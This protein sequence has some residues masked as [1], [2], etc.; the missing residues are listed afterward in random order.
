MPHP[1]MYRGDRRRKEDQRKAKQEAKKVRRAE[2][3]ETGTSGPEIADQAEAGAV[4]IVE[5]VWFSPSKGADPDDA[6]Q[7]GADGGRDRRLDAAERAAG[8]ELGAGRLGRAGV[9]A[10]WRV[11][12]E[13]GAPEERGPEVFGGDGPRMAIHEAVRAET[14]AGPDDEAVE[15][16]EAARGELA[17]E[18]D[19]EWQVQQHAED[20]S[21][22]PFDAGEPRDHREEHEQ[23]IGV[24]HEDDPLYLAGE[25]VAE[26]AAGTE[27][28]LTL[29][30]HVVHHVVHV[31]QEAAGREARGERDALGARVD[32]G[33]GERGGDEM[34]SG[35]DDEPP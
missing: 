13:L 4:E 15:G 33:A 10:P 32:G 30:E 19:I 14:R 29:E 31:D 18:D 17:V 9:L 1:G 7:G 34:A 26:E 21:P 12:R 6:E 35:T 11:V 3:R 8:R 16:D 2:R 25:I 23:L 27:I 24:Q 28:A 20:P 22:Q 5:F